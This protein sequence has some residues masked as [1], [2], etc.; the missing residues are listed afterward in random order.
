MRN[1]W[2]DS[3]EW[4]GKYGDDDENWTESLR[5]KYDN[6][7]SKDDGRFFIPF[8]NFVNYFDQFAICLYRDD[9]TMSCFDEELESEY[10]GCYKFNVETPGEYFISLSQ[11]DQR[12]FDLLPDGSSKIKK[13]ISKNQKNL[14]KKN[15][16]MNTVVMVSLSARTKVEK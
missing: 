16:H 12:G 6:V 7:E 1:P 9:Y 5:E 4:T 13:F 3:N 15:K 14:T 10:L 8:E 2:G 11:P